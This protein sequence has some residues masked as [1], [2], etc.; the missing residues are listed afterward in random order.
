VF[1]PGV[2]FRNQ[3]CCFFTVIPESDL[4]KVCCSFN[5][6]YDPKAK[7][8]SHHEFSSS[9][10]E[11]IEGDTLFKLAAKEEMKYSFNVLELSTKYQVLSEKTSF[12]G[13]VKQKEKSD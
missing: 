6:Q 2:V 4:D 8:E 12:V 9:M 7:G 13:V 3:L 10:F 11:L 1:E 5:C